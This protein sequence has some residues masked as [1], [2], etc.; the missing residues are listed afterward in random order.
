MSLKL[1]VLC[2]LDRLGLNRLAYFIFRNSGVILCYHGI[3]IDDEH[4]F[5]PANYIRLETFKNKIE[6]M[7]QKGYIFIS[8]QEFL[9]KKEQG[10][11]NCNEAVLTI[12]DGFR[13]SV[14]FMLPF[15][16]EK[17]IPSTLYLTTKNAESP[18]PIFRLIFSYVIWKF[19]IKE[20]ST[21]DFGTKLGIDS[22][23]ETSEKEKMWEFIKHIENNFT[24]QQ[25]EEIFK[26]FLFQKNLNLD[27]E[28][29]ASF[30]LSSRDE[31]A[32]LGFKYVDIQLHTHSHDMSLPLEKLKKDILINE[33]LISV[34]SDS[35]KKHFC[36]P[37]GVY[38]D[39]HI[40]M[41]E[42]V[43]IE[44]ATTCQYGLVKTDTPNLELPRI[45]DAEN[46]PLPLFKAKLSGLFQILI[47]IKN[48]FVP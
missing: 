48:I 42:S 36:Y 5:L 8:L 18:Y 34:F 44:S 33:E 11:L 25:R 15:L 14:E 19:Q 37:S 21:E 29:Y 3:S 9:K 20:F 32:K 46:I 31:I 10:S 28:V 12:D 40:P 39:K 27:Q 30:I 47:R 45:L 6:W 35:D 41:L 13:S 1:C 2:F 4:D 38:E 22:M 26:K 43:N 23:I 17:R 7:L 24:P 16:E